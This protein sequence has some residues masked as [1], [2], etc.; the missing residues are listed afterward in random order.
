MFK[1]I[2]L[3]D[4]LLDTVAR[5]TVTKLLSVCY[6]VHSK[7]MGACVQSR[8]RIPRQ[9]MVWLCG[10]HASESILCIEEPREPP[11]RQSCHNRK[12][13]CTRQTRKMIGNFIR[14]DLDGNT[15]RPSIKVFWSANEINERTLMST[16]NHVQFS[17]TP[18]R[19]PDGPSGPLGSRE[20]SVIAS[21]HSRPRTGLVSEVLIR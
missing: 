8:R 21:S 20:R 10:S 9:Q 13:K 15:G 7:F 6:T 5:R 14:V 3:R 19:R 16:T 17:E 11:R 12:R 18:D 4:V 1:L 2:S